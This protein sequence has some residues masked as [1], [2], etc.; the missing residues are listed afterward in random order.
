VVNAAIRALAARAEWT[1]EELAEYARL[2]AEWRA[3]VDRETV[4]PAA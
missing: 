3:A 2:R 4:V 1:P